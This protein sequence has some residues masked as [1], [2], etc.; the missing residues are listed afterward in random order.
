SSRQGVPEAGMKLLLVLDQF[1]QWLH[2][3]R[4]ESNTELVEALRQC[5]GQRVQCLIL[6][7]DDFGM[8]VTRFMHDLEIPILEGKN[9]ATVDLFDPRHARKILAKFGHSFGSL[10]DN[11]S[12]TTPEQERFLDEAV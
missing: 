6:V 3:R 9:F 11:P 2:A 7:R 12:E 5:D 4:E 1:E 10:P 8:A